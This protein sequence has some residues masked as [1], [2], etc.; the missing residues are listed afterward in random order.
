MIATSTPGMFF[1]MKRNIIECIDGR[2]ARVT[3][4]Q[5]VGALVVG[6]R[7]YGVGGG[8]WWQARVNT[9]QEGGVWWQ[10]RVTS[11]KVRVCWQGRATLGQWGG[12][13]VGLVAGQ[14]YLEEGQGLL[15]GKSYLGAVG[16][17]SGGSQELPWGRWA[18]LR[19]L[20][21]W[22]NYPNCHIIWPNQG[23]LLIQ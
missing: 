20:G 16:G 6:K 19:V 15:V 2:R 12:G 5:G 4:G 23:N 22:G 3:S 18:T 14:S 8:L 9:G 13:A 1:L 10:T 11:G 7:K 21:V 17:G